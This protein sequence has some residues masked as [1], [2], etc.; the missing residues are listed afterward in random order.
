MIGAGAVLQSDIRIGADVLVAAGTVVRKPVP[1]NHIVSGN[2]GRAV[3]RRAVP[4]TLGRAG[5][6]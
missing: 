3:P 2:P 6:E 1:D 5:D 4:S